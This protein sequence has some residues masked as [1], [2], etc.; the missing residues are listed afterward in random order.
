MSGDQKQGPVVQSALLRNELVRFRADRVMTQ[1][2]VTGTLAWSASKLIRVE[3]HERLTGFNRAARDRGWWNT[4]RSADF[5]DGYLTYVGFEAGASAIRA[6]QGSTIPG[7][8]QTREYAEVL[9]ENSIDARRVRS[10]ADLGMQRHLRLLL[11][12]ARPRS[13]P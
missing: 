3:Q 11:L 7:L 4:C 9:T 5:D 6:F 12:V 13:V 10:M 2:Q 1:E 8:L